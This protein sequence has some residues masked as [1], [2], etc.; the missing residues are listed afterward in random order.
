MDNKKAIKQKNL[1]E[2]MERFMV[3]KSIL[4]VTKGVEALVT[5]LGG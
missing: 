4:G 2:K 3:N 1:D 5:C